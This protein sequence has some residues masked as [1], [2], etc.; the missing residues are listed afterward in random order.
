[1]PELHQGL[2]DFPT[3]ASYVSERVIPYVL[4]DVETVFTGAAQHW[5]Q[6][7]VGRAAGRGDFLLAT[8]L[9]SL[10]DHF[11]SFLTGQTKPT[12]LNI[13]ASAKRVPG[14]QGV[15]WLLAKA[16]RNALVHNAFP[17]TLIAPEGG[18]A[19]GLSVSA[20]PTRTDLYYVHT[21]DSSLHSED[22]RIE[23]V[24]V[25]QVIVCVHPW[26]R[27]LHDAVVSDRMFG[28]ADPS[29]FNRV[30]SEAIRKCRV[31]T[32]KLSPGDSAG[33][34]ETMDTIRRRLAGP[35]TR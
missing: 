31:R 22:G 13:G 6:H 14:F 33:L 3:L 32:S 10:M 12:A 5:S 19:F 1:M 18:R 8:L 11:G 16:G 2:W 21:R 7:G 28:R 9:L 25:D 17:Q 15:E 20:N 30:R 27:A 29:H 23:R 35:D 4:E 34:V 24:A 26:R